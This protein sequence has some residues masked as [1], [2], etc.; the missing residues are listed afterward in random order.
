MPPILAQIKRNPLIY[1]VY[2][3]SLIFAFCQSLLIPILPLYILEF[4]GTYW[5]VGIV[6][7][8]ASLGMLAGDIPAGMLLRVL[9]EKK[10]MIVGVIFAALTTVALFWAQSI[11][12]AFMYRLMTGFSIAL[13]NI[14]RHSYLAQAVSITNRGRA[15][16]I[17]GGVNRIGKFAGPAVG[18]AVALTYGLRAP[19]LLFGLASV[20]VIIFLVGFVKQPESD[21]PA[22]VS[23]RHAHFK[24]LG[25]MI[26]AHYRILGVAGSAQ[27]FA[28]TV[29]A[30]RDVIIPLYGADM[31][32]LDVAEIGWIVSLSSAVDMSL[33]YPAGYLMD[34]IGRKYAIVPCFSIQAL[35]MAL[36]PL[37]GGFSGLLA[38][39]CLIGFGNGLGSGTMMT[40]GADLAPLESRGEFL[41]VWRLIGDIG[42]AGGPFVVGGVAAVL[43]LPLSA[44]AM[45]GAGFTSA[46]IFAFLVPETLKKQ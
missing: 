44:L 13:F 7:A 1:P 23:E 36:I 10:A 15:I 18:G 9:G 8:G 3:P 38:V 28:Q 45:A 25:Q 12:E 34:H 40:L 20:G 33:F 24:H 11:P 46:F 19:F 6:I 32:G 31:L 41:G 27:I 14:S 16:A 37:T 22:S 43:T 30:G 17:F 35:G 26:K 2:V 21:I 39:A 29:R 5:A 4:E 42:G